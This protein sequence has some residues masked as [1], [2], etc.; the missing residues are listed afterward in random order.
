MEEEEIMKEKVY[1]TNSYK[2]HY[3][4][5]DKFK[6]VTMQVIFRDIAT[7]EELPYRNLLARVLKSST[8]AYP[9]SRLFHIAKQELY[10]LS[11]KIENIKRGNYVSTVF[12]ATFLNEKYTEK[13]MHEKSVAFLMDMIFK[14]NMQH[15]CFE[16]RSILLAKKKLEEVYRTM[17]EDKRSYASIRLLENLEEEAPY[18]YGLYPNMEV[19]ETIRG[20][21]LA[22]Y[23]QDFLKKNMVDV[24][25]IGDFDEDEMTQYIERFLHI[26]TLKKQKDEIFYQN[27]NYRTRMKR[28]IEKDEVIQ[29]KLVLGVKLK[30]LTP[31]E[32]EYVF[33][34][35]N[36]IMGS[37][38][39]SKFFKIIREKESLCYYIHSV[40]RKYDSLLLISAGINRENVGKT[41][42][43]V[44][45]IVKMMIDGSFDEIELATAKTQIEAMLKIIEDSPSSI[46]NDYY[47]QEIAGMENIETRKES[48]ARVTKEDIQTVAKKL[49]FYTMYFLQGEDAK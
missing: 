12:Q 37:G 45:K 21:E 28:V 14:P 17:K 9:T 32:R 15:G 38:T 6:T 42:K 40:Y 3:I 49:S 23:Y 47:Y 13:G 24:Y 5:T 20:E 46:L 16:E 30:D 25:V 8:E 36:L 18:T 4:K 29:G 43:L 48:Y 33:P 22:T 26:N 35:F 19:I 27:K 2:V 7:K 10:A 1:H 11:T 34:I 31:F 41:V 44:K 39:D